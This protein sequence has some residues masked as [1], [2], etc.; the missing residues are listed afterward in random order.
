MEEES[1]LP[2]KWCIKRTK[3][4]S[5]IINKWNTDHPLFKEQKRAP[6]FSIINSDYF[7]SDR[8]HTNNKDSDYIEITFEQFKKYVLEENNNSK[9]IIGSWYKI[10]DCSKSYRKLKEL[11][12]DSIIYN[13]LIINANHKIS[14]LNFNG[15]NR[16]IP[17][18]IEEIQ[19]YLPDNHPDKILNNNFLN[20]I[21]E[22]IYKVTF[23]GNKEGIIFKATKTF[24]LGGGL[25]LNNTT[26]YINIKNSEYY[27]GV[28]CCSGTTIEFTI[29]KAT[30]EEIR[31]L[32]TCIEINKF[33]SKEI[34][35][36]ECLNQIKIAKSKGSSMEEILEEVKRF[37]LIGT[38]IKSLRG[39]GAVYID[40]NPNYIISTNSSIWA[41][42]CDNKGNSI[43][44]SNVP[45]YENGKWAEVI[46]EI[47]PI[48]GWYNG[49]KVEISRL[50]LTT[51][52]ILYIIENRKNKN[53]ILK[54]EQQQKTI[55]FNKVKRKN[56]LVTIK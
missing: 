14:E 33:I 19:Q 24:K 36:K 8:S 9:F 39:H 47:E 34:I 30:K 6:S 52:P 20:L 55:T 10:K 43:K 21:P 42:V 53:T 13:E 32:E 27:N 50:D 44:G 12:S 25:K 49:Y 40:K 22:E 11:K 51:E 15:L 29:K 1:K 38:K 48:D 26:K 54:G 31:W 46:E 2:E 4:N 7:Y 17:I 41:N 56:K 18:S 16:L 5:T 28:S 37:Y 3:E 35:E 45:I 23:N